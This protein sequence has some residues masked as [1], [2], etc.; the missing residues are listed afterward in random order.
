MSRLRDVALRRALRLLAEPAAGLKQQG[1]GVVVNEAGAMTE[2]AF[3]AWKQ[4]TAPPFPVGRFKAKDA[5]ERASSAWGA[6]ALPWFILADK[7]HRVAAEGFT[8]ED[9]EQQLKRLGKDR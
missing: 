5:A 2:E 8:L 7:S 1:L 9:L 4:E 6:T 3:A